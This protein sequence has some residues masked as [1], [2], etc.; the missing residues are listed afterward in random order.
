[1]Q[2]PYF[3]VLSPQNNILLLISWVILVPSSPNANALYRIPT[4]IFQS[5]P[6]FHFHFS[7]MSGFWSE[8][9]GATGCSLVSNVSLACNEDVY[10]NKKN[11]HS[12]I[13]ITRYTW[14]QQEITS[15]VLVNYLE[16]GQML[17]FSSCLNF[18]RFFSQGHWSLN[19][20]LL[21][22]LIM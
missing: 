20:C 1:M 11:F 22:R 12:W 18:P 2:V 14:T 9:A 13:G 5:L 7:K 19:S 21:G 16:S 15:N 3:N 10:K 8:A 17:T 6:R 4:Q